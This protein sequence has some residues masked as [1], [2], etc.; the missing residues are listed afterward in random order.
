MDE[1]SKS[2]KLFCFDVDGTLVD[3]ISWLL[4]TQGLGCAVQ[5]HL[6]IF[7]RAKNGE[8]SFIEGE[9]LLTKM[10]QGSG[11]ANLD[12]I[13]SIFRKVEPKKEAFEIVSFLKKKGYKIYLV[14]GAIDLFVEEI[15][16]K[17]DVNGYYA[18][19]TLEFD[20]K[21]ILVKIHYR[22]NQG[23]VKVEQLKEL[24]QKEGIAINEVTFIG[25]SSNDIESFEVTKNGIAVGSSNKQLKSVAWKVID[26][27]LEIKEVKWADQ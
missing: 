5:D 1:N 8:I 12:F 24:I 13:K 3:G 26:S 27:L 20:D 23:D 14:S 6:D 10:Y 17:L 15:F 4:L 16:K 22:D 18:N 7:Q 11:K 2:I 25:D 21:G 9:R 19:S